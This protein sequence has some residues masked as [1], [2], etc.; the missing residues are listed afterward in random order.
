MTSVP[1]LVF[2]F[3]SWYTFQRVPD[4]CKQHG[5]QIEN[6]LKAFKARLDPKIGAYFDTA[7]E[8][9]NKEDTFVAEAL[10]YSRTFI[11]AGGK[12]LRAA[13]MYYG[14]L[15]AG[16]TEEDKIL[17]TS[18]SI[19]LIHAF[20]LVHD[21]II[22]KDDT[23]HGVATLHRHYADAGQL[24]F[25]GKD[26]AHF[27]NAMAIIIG[28]MLGAFG[29]DIIFS[30]D[31]PLEQK[32]KALSNCRT[33]SLSRSSD[34]PATSI[35]S[36]GEPPARRRSSRCIGTRLPNIR[37]RGR[38]ISERCSPEPRRICLTDSRRMRYR[39]AS[40]SDSGR[41][42]GD[43]RQCQAPR[44]A[45]RLRHRRGQDHAARVSGAA[46]RNGRATKTDPR[47]AVLGRT[48][49]TAGHR[50]FRD[51]IRVTGAFEST[52]ALAAAYIAEGKQALAAGTCY[53][54]S[55]RV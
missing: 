53:P 15:G 22:D 55:A 13:F 1:S 43:F 49:R 2:G 12:R 48:S 34:R 17:E 37:S 25:P 29:N 45:D 24:L 40:L 50:E 33:S 14:Y 44:Q 35:W 30:S 8:R 11:L 16:G 9:T 5:M 47:A 3:F 20:L 21:D 27:G 39:W 23:R 51:I 46:G 32:F 52:Q 10:E 41:Y 19:E 31:F 18:M 7:I 42:P 38:S 4:D 6:E 54:G 36:S 28:D 26:A